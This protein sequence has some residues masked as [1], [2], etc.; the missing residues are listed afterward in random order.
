LAQHQSSRSAHTRKNCSVACIFD[1]VAAITDAEWE[2]RYVAYVYQIAPKI[3][4]PGDR[5]YIA[6]LNGRFEESDILARYGSGQYHIKLNDRKIRKTIATHLFSVY[7][8]AKPPHCDP[9]LIVDCPENQPYLKWIKLAAPSP[10]GNTKITEE[11]KDGVKSPKAPSVTEE[12]LLGM[13]QGRD[14]LASKL[15]ETAKQPTVDPLTTL[16]QAVELI[17]SLHQPNGNSELFQFRACDC[18][19]SQTPAVQSWLGSHPTCN[20]RRK[21]QPTPPKIG[22]AG[23]ARNIRENSR[24]CR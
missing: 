7:D 13:A 18:R 23:P 4:L 12:L 19:H 5:H 10:E 8:P 15:A 9:C 2:S 1:R 3:N 6:R 24:Y 20:P 14:A 16:N 21:T 17:K 11:L 22:I